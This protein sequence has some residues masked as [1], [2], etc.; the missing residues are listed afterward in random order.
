[1]CIE[2]RPLN[3]VL[4]AVCVAL[5]DVCDVHCA[6]VWGQEEP[7]SQGSKGSKRLLTRTA[8]TAVAA[9][10]SSATRHRK[11]RLCALCCA[12]LCCAPCTA[13]CVLCALELFG[14]DSVVGAEVLTSFLHP[15]KRWYDINNTHFYVL[16]LRKKPLLSMF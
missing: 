3:F 5:C 12:V 11:R 2:L 16:E 14:R 4:C 9:A 15:G 7:F 1:M 13:C 8:R 10:T 6:C